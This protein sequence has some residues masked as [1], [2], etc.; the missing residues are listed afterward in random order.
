MSSSHSHR[1]D[2]VKRF[3]DAVIAALG[4]VVLSP[5]LAITAV[6][7]AI[8][9]GRP[10]FFTQKRPGK[11]G[12]VFRLYKFR[13]MRN[14]ESEQGLITD[15]QRLTGFGRALR[16]SSL[17]EL[18]A[19]INVAKGD[20]SIV[21]PRP[22]LVQYLERYSSRQARRHEVRPGI[23]GLAQVSG[24]NSLSWQEK[25]EFDVDYVEQRSAALDLRILARTVGSVIKREGISAD[26]HV[27][28]TEFMGDTTEGTHS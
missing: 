23:T 16:S 19:L 3:S 2:S 7:V 28:M 6:L 20:M 1:Y 4:L 9:L 25:F 14:I 17:D 22:L 24:R 12:V 26:A 15:E 8:K 13:T 10:V 27:T 5:V 18:P 11:D 21:G